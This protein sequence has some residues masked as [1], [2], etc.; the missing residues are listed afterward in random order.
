M[1]KGKLSKSPMPS[2]FSPSAGALDPFDT[3]A[4]DSSRLQALLGNSKS[5]YPIPKELPETEW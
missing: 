5:R 1:R 3:L 2:I 4:V